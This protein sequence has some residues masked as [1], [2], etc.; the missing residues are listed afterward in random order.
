MTDLVTYTEDEERRL[1]CEKLAL[2]QIKLREELSPAFR[3]LERLKTVAATSGIVTACIAM[4]GIGL[5]TLQWRSNL[6]QAEESRTSERVTAGLTDLSAERESQRLAGVASLTPFLRDSNGPRKLQVLRA[7][8][9][10]LASE[11]SDLIRNAMVGAIAGTELSNLSSSER[12]DVITSVVDI[13]RIVFASSRAR[14][15]SPEQQADARARARALGEAIAALFKNGFATTDLSGTYFAGVD[16]SGIRFPDGVK[17]DRGELMGTR[18]D[19]A[20]L[21]RASFRSTNLPLTSFVG[22]QLSG[23]DFSWPDVAEYNYGVRIS[24]IIR[25][26]GMLGS[27]MYSPNFRCAD[28]TNSSF[29]GFP[30]F[31]V[32]ADRSGNAVTSV[33]SVQLADLTGSDLRE[34]VII[35]SLSSS[36]PSRDKTAAGTKSRIT[37]MYRISQWASPENDNSVR[38]DVGQF[39]HLGE[40]SFVVT[41]DSKQLALY[42]SSLKE[43]AR[44]FEGARWRQAI[45]PP[46]VKTIFAAFPPAPANTRDREKRCAPGV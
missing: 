25:H 37:S 45:L 31:A 39:M 7:Y 44:N 42:S 32:F 16:L 3:R 26:G 28:L 43:M 2:E 13:N 17:F 12:S 36:E 11:S 8:A 41:P 10:A 24:G 5:T 22:A 18:F 21:K 46:A 23:A 34:A 15:R 27:V 29:R 35:G 14:S 38:L 6:A 9:N 4:I 19:D 1:R 30:L 40:A 20:T 33:P